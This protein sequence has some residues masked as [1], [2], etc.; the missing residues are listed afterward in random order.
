VCTPR[1]GETYIVTVT[2]ADGCQA[3]DTVVVALICEES[4][5]RVPDAF[6]PNGDGRNDR[7]RILGI[8]EV[9]HLVIYDR[10]GVKV[11][12]RDHFFTA[13]PGSGWDGTLGGQ[14]APAGVYAYF[15]QFTCPVGGAFARQ[16]TVVLIR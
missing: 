3:S 1:K 5:V 2:G 4:R 8:G 10:W 16:G 6:T 7:F 14:P 12:E 11:F 13:D 15:A 9:D